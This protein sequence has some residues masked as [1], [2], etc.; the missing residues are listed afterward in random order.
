MFRIKRILL[1][2]VFFSVFLSYGINS[3]VADDKGYHITDPS[4]MHLGDNNPHRENSSVMYPV[5]NNLE[6]ITVMSGSATTKKFKGF[7]GTGG[8]CI[9]P[10]S[11]HTVNIDLGDLNVSA[12]LSATLTVRAYDCDNQTTGCSGN[13]E[14]DSVFLNGNY[15]GILTG[16]TDQWSTVSFTINKD[17]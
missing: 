14:I 6:R 1:V 16:A 8:S 15:I 9:W 17:N 11:F 12:V 4:V 10:P 5:N 7:T 2:F 13:P 3:A